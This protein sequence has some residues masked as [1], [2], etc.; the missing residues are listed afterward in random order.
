MPSIESIFAVLLYL[1]CGAILIIGMLALYLAW[2]AITEQYG[3]ASTP[4]WA[5]TSSIFLC[6]VSAFTA[7]YGLK[8]LLW[9]KEGETIEGPQERE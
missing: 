6:L 9:R 1:F 5:R 7:G 3:F 2:I 8:K 4:L